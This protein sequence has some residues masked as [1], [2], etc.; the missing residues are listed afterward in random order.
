[1][2]KEEE[3]KEVL[4]A[5]FSLRKT[6]DRKDR[7]WTLDIKRSKSDDIESAN[8]SEISNLDSNAPIYQQSNN[9]ENEANWLVQSDYVHP[10][11]TDG[12][13]ETGIKS[14]MRAID[15]AFLLEQQQNNG[16]FEPLGSLDNEFIYLENIY[17][18]YAMYGNK[19]N[20]ISYQLG[21]RYEY[22]DIT[23]EL[24][25]SA[26]KNQ[27]DYQNLFPSAHI[28]YELKKENTLQ[29]SYSKRISRPRFRHLI[30]FSGYS[31][32]RNFYTGNPALQP[33]FS[34]STEIGHLKYW[35][36]GSLLSSIYYRYRTN[37]VERVRVSDSVGYT[38]LIPANLATQDAFGIELNA[39]YNPY[40]WWRI[41]SSINFYRAITSG[42]FEGQSLSS[43][44]Y[45]WN[46]KGNSKF[47]LSAKTAFSD[48]SQLSCSKR[49]N[50]RKC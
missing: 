18:T 42:S 20:A 26:E 37:V 1:M 16:V 13:F 4:E 32:S 24:K 19:I 49:N 28:S 45:T 27:L 40:K 23:T 5:N 50:A 29:I 41:N 6:F 48:F 38:R 10:I 39:S 30:P 12:R 17:A 36:K 21:M 34:H 25:K 44:T 7:E 47:S 2:E 22:S 43:D 31:D 11:G 3:D 14:T 9:T 33:E 46:G 15:N 8:L 35:E